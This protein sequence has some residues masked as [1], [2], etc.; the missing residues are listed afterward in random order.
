MTGVRN[1]IGLV[2]LSVLAVGCGGLDIRPGT[3]GEKGG[4]QFFQPKVVVTI[5]ALRQ[6][7]KPG[8]GGACAEGDWMLSCAVGSTWLLPDYSKPY[9]A[10]F[11]AGIGSQ[12][13]TL[14]LVDGWLLSKAVSETDITDLTGIALESVGIAAQGSAGCD[15]GIYEWTGDGFQK[16]KFS[17]E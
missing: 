11:R 10:R 16:L 1:T 8:S 12:K 13:A 2:I 15:E 5:S 14:D 7:V 3:V 17:G 6:C 4:Y 9:V